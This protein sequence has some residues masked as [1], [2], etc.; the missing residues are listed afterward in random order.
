MASRVGRKEIPIPAGVTIAES[1]GVVTVSGP[2]GALTH[3][4]GGGVGIEQKDGTLR[5][6]LAG[7]DD[8]MHGVTRA[9]LANHVR[10]VHQ[11]F[12]RVL[13]IVGTGY[14]AQ[15]QGKTLVLSLGFSHP[16]EFPLPEGIQAKVEPQTRI[17]LSG[18]NRELLGQVAANIRG[19]RPPEPYKGKGVKYE[20]E[21]IRRKA[22]K[23]VGGGAS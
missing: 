5:V 11:G 8:A 2:K 19:I 17:E 14:R 13:E 21:H 18:M 16:V 20:G 22:G 3:R 9:V 1:G 15:L 23:S 6:I 4:L 7:A 12:T 10:G